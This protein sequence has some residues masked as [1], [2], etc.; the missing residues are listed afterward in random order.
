MKL[1]GTSYTKAVNRPDLKEIPIDNCNP[2]EYA[3]EL[4]EDLVI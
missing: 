1:N 3:E 2:C 4:H